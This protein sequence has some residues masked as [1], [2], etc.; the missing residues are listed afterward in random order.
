MKYLYDLPIPAR[1]M[2]MLRVVG[3]ETLEQLQADAPAKIENKL[4]ATYGR[5]GIPQGIRRAMQEINDIRL[6]IV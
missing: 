6:G 2:N 3:Y 4:I 1:T 5:I